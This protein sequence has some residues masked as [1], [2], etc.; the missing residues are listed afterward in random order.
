MLARFHFIMHTVKIISVY[1]HILPKPHINVL[2]FLNENEKRVVLYNFFVA[3]NILN[4]T[5]KRQRCL[6]IFCFT[7]MY[8]RSLNYIL[9]LLICLHENKKRQ[10]V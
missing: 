3:I 5:E 1:V 2:Y 10:C 6:I 4:E 8:V 7:V 9:Q